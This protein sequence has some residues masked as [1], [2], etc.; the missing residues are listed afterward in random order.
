M[1]SLNRVMI[2]GRL[3]KDPELR[4]TKNREPVT[5]LAVATTETWKDHA[6]DKKE[7]T[8]WHTVVI[9]GKQAEACS[10]HLAK[11]RQVFIEGALKTRSWEDKD[12]TKRYSTEITAKQ[13]L[14][15]AA[16]GGEKPAAARVYTEAKAPPQIAEHP[17]GNDIPF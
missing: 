13:V 7:A 1:S 9:W 3:G 5:T 17:W 15:T 16:P 6:G 10:Q 8:E 4:Y 14:F 11:G 2:L 12:G